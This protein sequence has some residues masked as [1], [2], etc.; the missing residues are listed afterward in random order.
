MKGKNARSKEHLSYEVSVTQERSWDN[1]A[2]SYSPMT[3]GTR[4]KT[5]DQLP[6]LTMTFTSKYVLLRIKSGKS[7]GYC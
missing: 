4:V 2:L 6:L 3:H 1:D 7:Y 5:K